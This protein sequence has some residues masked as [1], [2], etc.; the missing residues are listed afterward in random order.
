VE[1]KRA[2]YRKLLKV[3]VLIAIT[4]QLLAYLKAS[5][6]AK[7]CRKNSAYDG[8]STE[9]GFSLT[10]ALSAQPF[11]ADVCTSVHTLSAGSALFT[12]CATRA[13]LP[14]NENATE[15][16]SARTKNTPTFSLERNE[17][18]FMA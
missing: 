12:G 7:H 13:L 9:P 2:A 18:L 14:S 16:R 10:A 11:I 5:I 8:L 6:I 17:L 4:H 1:S 15:T 3:H